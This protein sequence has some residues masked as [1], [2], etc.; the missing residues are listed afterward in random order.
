MTISRAA[1]PQW[2]RRAG[3]YGCWLQRITAHFWDTLTARKRDGS[4]VTDRFVNIDH[5]DH[6][7]ARGRARAYPKKLACF[8]SV[9]HDASS[10]LA[11][12]LKL[13]QRHI[14]VES[15]R[16]NG[17]AVELHA[18]AART[19]M[20]LALALCLVTASDAFQH[21]RPAVK[22]IV[23]HGKTRGDGSEQPAEDDGP[24]DIDAAI[25]EALK[26]PS[27][28]DAISEDINAAL[29]KTTRRR[30]RR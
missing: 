21:L 1:T 11:R 2:T 6:A 7:K 4:S 26:S 28:V 29:Q 17:I 20:K 18:T 13:T 8:A 25:D 30:P 16:T 9:L 23:L 10:P 19:I 15:P 14:A 27:I 22:P 3:S 12:P 24:L 5:K